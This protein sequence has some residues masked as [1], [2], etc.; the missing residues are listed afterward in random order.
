MADRLT[1]KDIARELKIHHSTVS[2]AL[3]NDSRVN[4]ETQHK[5]IEYAQTHGYQTNLS[6]L[7]LRGEKKKAISILVPNID[8][9]FFSNFISR[10]TDLANNDGYVVTIYQS[11]EKV[12]REKQIIDNIIQ[13]NAIGVIASL[14]METKTWKH[15][16]KMKKYG[17]PLV[18]F[19]RVSDEI[20]VPKI[21]L[22][23][24]EVVEEVVNKLIGRG[25]KK[26]AHITGTQSVSVFRENQKGYLRALQ[27]SELE[28]CKTII[29]EKGFTI[30]DGRQETEKL[31]KQRRCS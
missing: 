13:N 11:N 29:I 17:I 26:I 19:D 1:I 18:L 12:K 24:S 20:N 31:L 10:V 9:E 25:Y 23:H 22:S 5:V 4:K 8:H 14:S 30:E 7:E 15:L 28:Y 21:T 16:S 6:A 27:L 2:R 3:R